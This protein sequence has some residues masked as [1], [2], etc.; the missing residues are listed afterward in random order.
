MDEKRS[1]MTAW[2]AGIIVGMV[3]IIAA[4]SKLILGQ[5]DLSAIPAFIPVWFLTALPY[6]ELSVGVML[7]IGLAVKFNAY[8][9]ALLI[10][11]FAVTNI[12]MLAGGAEGCASCFGGGIIITPVFTLLLDVLMA[13]MVLCIFYCLKKD[14]FFNILPW[15]LVDFDDGKYQ[16]GHT[17]YLRRLGK[18][19]R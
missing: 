9:S 4:A 17:Q 1:N 10:L 2:A 5:G 8:I 3:L 19:A 16:S 14:S 6:I 18:G 12:V 13:L 7:L 11:G 15:Y